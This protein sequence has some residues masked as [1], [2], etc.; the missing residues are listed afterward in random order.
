VSNQHATVAPILSVRVVAD[1]DAAIEHINT[2]SSQH[3]ES[4]VTEDYSRARRSQAIVR[5]QLELF[6][7]DYQLLLTPTT[8]IA[9]PLIEGP[10]AVEQARLLTRY[11]APFNL[12]G[13]PAL[14]MPC[15]FTRQGLP[16]GLQ[17]VAWSWRDGLLLQAAHAYEQAIGWHTWKP[18]L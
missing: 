15:G 10:D 2:Y 8:P 17:L 7:E 6:F 3:T 14:S 9:A 13:L 18:A 5:R 12:S 16:I 1:L 11:T 4:I